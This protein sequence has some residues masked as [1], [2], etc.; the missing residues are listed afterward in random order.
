APSWNLAPYPFIAGV[1]MVAAYWI[2]IRN[3]WKVKDV[4]YMAMMTGSFLLMLWGISLGFIGRKSLGTIQ[5]AAAF[6]VFMIP[7]PAAVRAWIEGVSQNASA[8]VA[9]FFLRITGM[10]VFRIGTQFRLPGFSLEVAPECSGIHSTLVLF[11]TSLM[12]GHLFLRSPWKQI[13]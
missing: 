8:D 1:G 5:F 6:L 11:I 3:G 4:D 7:F 10:P 9:H 13:F 2:A 12:A